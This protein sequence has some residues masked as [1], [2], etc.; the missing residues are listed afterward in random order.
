MQDKK[1]KDKKGTGERP[2]LPDNI[3]VLAYKWKLSQ[4]SCLN[5]GFILDNFPKS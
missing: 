1:K 3:V 5:R 4:N 2:K